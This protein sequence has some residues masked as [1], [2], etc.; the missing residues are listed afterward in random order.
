MR[1]PHPIEVYKVPFGSATSVMV[2][3]YSPKGYVIQ[4]YHELSSQIDTLA[5]EDLTINEP[6]DGYSSEPDPANSSAMDRSRRLM[7]T[8]YL[9]MI[10][11]YLDSQPW[12]ICDDDSLRDR[13]MFHRVCSIRF[14]LLN[15]L[16][17]IKFF[18]TYLVHLQSEVKK[19]KRWNSSQS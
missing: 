19:E 11:Q 6:R 10:N 3:E 2:V 16:A 14:R 5:R 18:E 1:Q 15:Q 17:L 9:L 13:S 4:S 8:Y 7:E 12:P